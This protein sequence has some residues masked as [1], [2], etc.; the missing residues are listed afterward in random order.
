MP[1]RVLLSHHLSLVSVIKAR[2]LDW[3]AR[4]LAGHVSMTMHSITTMHDFGSVSRA[5]QKVYFTVIAPA[6]AEKFNKVVCSSVQVQMH[7]YGEALY[8][9]L[10]WLGE[11]LRCFQIHAV[12]WR[13]PPQEDM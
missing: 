5:R 4:C 8:L 1:T 3:G 9:F 13:L 11:Q 6:L 12:S 7:Q 2:V 10:P